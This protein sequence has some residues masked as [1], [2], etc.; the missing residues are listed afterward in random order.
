MVTEILSEGDSGVNGGLTS[1]YGHVG[2]VSDQASALHDVVLF[3][4]HFDSEFG[5][6]HEYFGHLVTTLTTNWNEEGG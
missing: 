1:S 5:E 4:I 2:G 3:P 6:L